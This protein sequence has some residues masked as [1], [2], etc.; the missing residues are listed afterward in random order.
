[1]PELPD[2]AIYLE[3]LERRILGAR[4][5]GMR[6]ASPFLVR[7]VDPP[8]KTAVGHRVESLRRLGKRIVI[9]LDDGLFL[10]L[11]LMIAGRLQ[12]ATAGADLPGKKGLA[13]FDFETGTLILTE[14]GSKKRASLHLVQG[15]AALVEHD[16]G[17]VEPLAIDRNAFAQALT[18]E[19]HTL[20]RTLTDPHLFAGIGN[21]YSDEIL[22]AAKLS[23]IAMS[24]GLS[25]AET[26]RL[27][28]ATRA[29][30]HAWIERGRTETGDG[31]PTKV[32]AFRPAM[33][34]HGKYGKPCPAC[35]TAIQR[36]VYA[37]NET[38]YCPR[39]QTGGRLLVD[40]ALSQVLKADW[41]K[42]IDELERRRPPP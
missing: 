29:T 17:G 24:R 32:T 13:A 10:V 31:W 8:V 39:C 4:I 3:A 14:M 5:I 33:A 37:S 6:V 41:P 15:E 16:P 40:R 19:N 36:I 11:H 42:T 35:G 7:S 22:H 30:L 21:A 1:M 25:E 23:P 12:W 27:F 9:G 26:T 20:K 18:A 38:N 28:E 34:A 2:I